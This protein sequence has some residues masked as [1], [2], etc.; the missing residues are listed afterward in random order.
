MIKRLACL[1]LALFLAEFLAAPALAA[2]RTGFDVEYRVAFVPEHK[3]ADVAIAVRSGTGRLN[4]LDL[5]MPADRYTAIAGD[6]EIERRGER[7]LW[8]VPARGGEL[9]YR[10][11]ID[12]RRRGNG[13]D[14]RITDHWVIVRGDDLVPPATARTSPGADSNARLRFELPPGWTNVDTGWKLARDGERFVVVNPERRFD[15]PVGWVIAGEV[16]TRREFLEGTEVSVAAPKGEPLHRN[17]VLAMVHVT[18]PEMRAA[19]GK[20]PPKL[21]IVGAGDPMWRGGLSGP[22]SLWMHADRPLISENGTSTLLHELTHV[23]TRIQGKHEHWIAEGI[24]EYYSLALLH[25]SGLIS[26]A[27]YDKALAWMRNHGKRVKT[28]RGVRSHGPVTAR[29]V[30]LFVALDREIRERTDEEKSLDDVVQRLMKIRTPT[31]EELRDVVADVS[32]APSDVLDTPV[33]R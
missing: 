13:Y 19:F 24:A 1:L 14:A 17:E 9:R 31:L 18:F 25:R 11:A 22:R 33:L 12:K 8:T 7:V 27:R 15:R 32:G 2:E 4:S 23:I 21:L 30:T 16:G 3:A 29:A 26:D 5:R 6:G 28:L 10:Y 20:L